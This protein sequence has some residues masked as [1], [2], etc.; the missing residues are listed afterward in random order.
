MNLTIEQI[1]RRMADALVLLSED[2]FYGAQSILEQVV[3]A[4]YVTEAEDRFFACPD[5]GG[6][7]RAGSHMIRMS[8]DDYRCYPE[9][10]Y[11]SEDERI[12][13]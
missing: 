11:A 13:F 4:N 5:C 9:A 8:V 10:S 1:Y 2:D 7:I 3:P 12:P 6:D